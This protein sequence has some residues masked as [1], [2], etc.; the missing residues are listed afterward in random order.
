MITIRL[1]PHNLSRIRFP[2]PFKSSE[3]YEITP[4]LILEYTTSTQPLIQSTAHIVLIILLVVFGLFTTIALSGIIYKM[5]KHEIREIPTVI[6]QE[7]SIHVIKQESPGPNLK[8]ED[9]VPI[10]RQKNHT[11]IIKQESPVPLITQEDPV[12][13]KTIKKKL[14]V[15]PV[16][17]TSNLNE[18]NFCTSCG[19]E[20]SKTKR[21]SIN[22]SDITSGLILSILGGLSSIAIGFWLAGIYPNLSS[23][24]SES[25]IIIQAIT[26]IG[27]TITLIGTAIVPFNIKVAK[28]IILI[29]GI[30]SGGNIITIIGAISI[31]KK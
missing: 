12:A 9:R 6:I 27:G 31:Q 28:L 5:R 18:W 3:S 20:I 10:I 15:C 16:C 11:S 8:Q 25:F 7:S 30:V 26:I 19:K 29:S 1:C 17:G 24:L 22:M 4:R 2:A 23:S 14:N 13:M 21:N